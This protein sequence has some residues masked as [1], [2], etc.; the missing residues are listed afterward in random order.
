MNNIYSFLIGLQKP[1]FC[2]CIPKYAKNGQEEKEPIGQEDKL[3]HIF[4]SWTLIDHW[5]ATEIM[6]IIH[7]NISM[8]DMLAATVTS[9]HIMLI[10]IGFTHQN[11]QD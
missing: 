11:T 7:R 4:Y 6:N 5:G 9:N 2:E 8:K 3:R 1:I 10:R